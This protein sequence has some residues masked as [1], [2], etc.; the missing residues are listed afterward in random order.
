MPVV[1]QG[2]WWDLFQRGEPLLWESLRHSPDRV[3]FMSP[4]YHISQGPPMEDPNLKQ[5]WFAHWL[6]GAKNGVQRTPHVNLYA[7]NG[8]HWEHFTRF[9]VPETSYQHM[10]LSGEPSGSSPISLHDGSLASA[11]PAAESGETAPL[12]PASSPCSRET[13]QWMTGPTRPV[14]ARSPIRPRRCSRT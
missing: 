7:I 11:P 6:Q 10:Y 4:H 9:P 5:E 12:L 14:P 3:L 2:G 8:Q 1:I 13:A